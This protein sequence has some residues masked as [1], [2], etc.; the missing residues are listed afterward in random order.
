MKKDL[1]NSNSMAVLQAYIH[2]Y[3]HFL[4]SSLSGVYCRQGVEC[5]DLVNNYQ[6]ACPPGYGG[7]RCE[8]DIGECE[9]NPCGGNGYVM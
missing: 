5:V 3:I 8:R 2:T 4:W 1:K 7:R 6:C 9:A